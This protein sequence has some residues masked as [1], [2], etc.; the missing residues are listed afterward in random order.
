MSS[1][2]VEAVIA[3]LKLLNHR[4]YAEEI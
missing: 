2:D 1:T 3:Y 4:P